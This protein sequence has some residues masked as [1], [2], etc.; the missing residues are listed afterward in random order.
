MISDWLSR[1]AALGIVMLGLAGCVAYEGPGP[2]Y[3]PAYGYA[4]SYGY[5]YGP[6]Y[7]A[8][9]LNF[10]FGGDYREGHRHHWR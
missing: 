2:Y 10:E 9:S 5:A 4:P 7:V 3:A 1:A 8:S 6:P